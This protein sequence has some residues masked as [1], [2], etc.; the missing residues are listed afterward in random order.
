[1]KRLF[2][3]MIVGSASLLSAHGAQAVGQGTPD[4]AKAMTVKAVEYMKAVGPEK[5]FA[6]F[7][8]K[9]GPWHD[10]DLYVTVE[11]SN[12]IMLVNGS[13]PGL[14]RESMFLIS[15][16]PTAKGPTNATSWR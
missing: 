10:R 9:D 15:R 13:N 5:A 2:F 14:V 1:M 4:E 16:I 6:E 3:L 12:G 7:N 8:A 11:A